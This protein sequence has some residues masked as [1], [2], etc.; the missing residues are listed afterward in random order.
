MYDYD[1]PYSETV[2]GVGDRGGFLAPN[3][4]R[5]CW[6]EKNKIVEDCQEHEH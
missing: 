6:Q 2:D 4:C 3:E 1:L 5:R